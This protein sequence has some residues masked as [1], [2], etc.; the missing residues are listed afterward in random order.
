[1]K[2]HFLGVEHNGCDKG[3]DGMCITTLV[4]LGLP[5]GK[6]LPPLTNEDFMWVPIT[7]KDCIH[8]IRE[9][10]QTQMCKFVEKRP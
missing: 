6:G 4:S 2:T 8:F 3:K 7:N 9:G 1:M 5:K 10:T